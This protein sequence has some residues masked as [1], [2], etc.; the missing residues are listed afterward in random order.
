[1]SSSLTYVAHVSRRVIKFGGIGL[2]SFLFLWSGLTAAIK[3]YRAAHPP[4][5]APTVRFGTLNKIVFPEK[6]FEKKNFTA[7][8]PNDRFPKYK[9]QIL[10]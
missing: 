1:M 6:N 3:A 9:D 5:V 7:E 2:I 10:L 4:Y 8:L